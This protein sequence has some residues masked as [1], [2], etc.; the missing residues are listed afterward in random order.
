MKPVQVGSRIRIADT[1]TLV[2]ALRGT[3][4]RRPEPG[5]VL[6]AGRTTS[7]TGYLRGSDDASLYE[8]KDAP[9]LW[10][11]EWLEAF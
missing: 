3:A 8:L 5:Q 11:E 4:E 2:A 7:V 6:W 9:G 10:P 1:K